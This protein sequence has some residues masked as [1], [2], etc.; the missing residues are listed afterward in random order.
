V[1]NWIK[2]IFGATEKKKGLKLSDHVAQKKP[3]LLVPSKADLKKLTKAELEANGRKNGLE[4]DKR[5]TKDKLVNQ[6][7][8]HLKSLNG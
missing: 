1:L 7:H 8:K 5:L 4:L 6:L 2:K 3:L